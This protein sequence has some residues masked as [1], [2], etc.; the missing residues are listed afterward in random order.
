MKC[1]GASS[2]LLS[3]ATANVQ[4]DFYD[5][6][7]TERAYQERL[8]MHP[9]TINGDCNRDIGLDTVALE[10]GCQLDFPDDSSVSPIVV[11]F[12]QLLM[13]LQ[14]HHCL[15]VD[16]CRD[17]DQMDGATLTRTLTM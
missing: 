12:S 7:H 6:F 15:S 1:V 9:L 14:V 16:I 3:T 2:P 4:K 13:S 10:N 5:A 8:T 17:L 11:F